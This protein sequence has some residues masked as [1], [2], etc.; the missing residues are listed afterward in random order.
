MLW[1]GAQKA[2][3]AIL[4]FC[5]SPPGSWIAA[6]LGLVLGF[7]WWGH[8]Q[9]AAGVSDTKAKNAKIVEQIIERSNKI[10]LDV[11]M[12]F[13]MARLTNNEATQ[14]RL[15]DVDTHITPAVD[16]DYPVPCGFVRVFNDANHGPIPDPAACPDGAASDIALSAVGKV[17]TVNA[18]QYDNISSQLSALQD[19]IRQQQSIHQ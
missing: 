13:E 12:N 2:F 18:G 10:T 3:S 7:W 15:A 4:E 17:E 8:Q 14:R 1:G 11:E 16:G 19:W 5:S 6:A 9:Y